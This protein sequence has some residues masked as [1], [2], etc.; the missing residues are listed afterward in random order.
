MVTLFDET[1]KGPVSVQEV[2]DFCRS[3][4]GGPADTSALAGR[5][6]EEATELG[7]ACGLSAGQILAHV[8]DSIYNQALKESFHSCKTIFPSQLR[9]AHSVLD[10]AGETADVVICAKRLAYE[11]DID[12]DMTE[13]RVFDNFKT[14]DLR[15]NDKGLI[16]ARKPHVK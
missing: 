12:L 9:R 6:I 3:V 15:A 1:Q 4:V 14:R 10:M 5:L 7:L 11:L 2:G 8:S 13:R 16:Y